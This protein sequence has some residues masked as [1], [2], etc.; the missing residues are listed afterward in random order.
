[1][2]NQV[3]PEDKRA[4]LSRLRLEIQRTP[5]F[6][7]LARVSNSSEVAALPPFP[8]SGLAAASPTTDEDIIISFVPPESF[9][10]A[11]LTARNANR[12]AN[13][14]AMPEHTRPHLSLATNLA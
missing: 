9:D 4:A 5:S 8:P 13:G 12:N 6:N 10:T 2:N 3:P 7:D 1:M 11:A 14:N